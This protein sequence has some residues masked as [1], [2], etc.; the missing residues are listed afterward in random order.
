MN[1][2]AALATSAVLAASALA[3]LVCPA[4]SADTAHHAAGQVHMAT[5]LDH[6]R[7]PERGGFE[8][9]ED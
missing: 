3:G 9:D 2:I 6:Q 8:W 1:K 5:S 4:A 7:L